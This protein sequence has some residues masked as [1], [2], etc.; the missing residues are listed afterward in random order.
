MRYW[1]IAIWRTVPRK[2]WIVLSPIGLLILAFLLWF[3]FAGFFIDGPDIPKTSKLEQVLAKAKA[4]DA[5]AQFEAAQILL[6]KQQKSAAVKWFE[7]S[8][9]KGYVDSQIVLARMY[10][11]G[12][13]VRQ[14]IARAVG[15]YRHA[16]GL[17][18]HPAAQF[19]LGNLYIQGRGVEQ[20]YATAVIWYQKAGLGGYGPA[21]SALG[22]MYEKGFGIDKNWAEAYAWYSLAAGQ[23]GQ[24]GLS[25]TL[26]NL[27]KRMSRL[28]IKRGKSRLRIYSSSKP[29]NK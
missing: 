8:A 9:K 22:A 16:A 21:R 18:N 29:V 19:E 10:R 4:G 28:Q 6:G 20:D 2:W 17:K 14:N 11:D 23:P 27:T 7:Q 13:G 3:L 25:K 1:F 15:L 12:D 26:D 24:P 5:R